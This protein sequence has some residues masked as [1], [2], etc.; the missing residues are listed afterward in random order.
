VGRAAPPLRAPEHTTLD[1]T[2]RRGAPGRGGYVGLRTGPG[3]PHVLRTDLA[4]PSARRAETRTALLAFAHL[5]DTH[6]VDAQSPARAEFLSRYGGSLRGGHRP[7][8]MLATQVVDAMAQAVRRSDRGPVTGRPLDLA[9]S[10]GDNVDNRQYNEVRWFLD[11]FDGGRT[12]TPDSGDRRRWEGVSDQDLLSYDVHYWHP[13]GQPAGREVDRLRAVHGYPTLPG[14]LDAC[15][16]PFTSTGLGV[17][18]YSVYGNHD[19][20]IQ[21][22]LQRNPS[23]GEYAVG[24][25]KHVGVG[26]APSDLPDVTPG[27]LLGG[28][29]RLVTPDPDRR[30]LTK[31]EWVA[32]HLAKPGTPHGHG[33]TRRNVD[34]DTAYYAADLTPQVRLLTLD[35]TT[36]GGY[37][38][39][40]LDVVQRDWLEAQLKRSSSRYLAPDGSWVAQ[41]GVADRLV[42]IASHH[43]VA[44]M[45]NVLLAPGETAPRVQ[46]DEV[47]ALLLRFPNVVA[48]INGHT[49]TNAV[50]PHKGSAGGFWEVTSASHIDW[51]QQSRLVELVDNR[52]GTL[53]LFGTVIDTAAASTGGLHSPL[54]LA[55]LSRELSANDPNTRADADPDARRGRAEGRNVELVVRAPFALTRR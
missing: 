21:G 50:T 25:V 54:A 9:L 45:D 28:P 11:L 46:G 26:P 53:S 35:S 17:P 37:D 48:W 10:T 18:W 51:P 19:G 44:T 38:T 4:T 43:T 47:L 31:R 32:E 29:A 16:R 33:F 55:G 2:L 36:P 30:F 7:H 12:V 13:D 27:V 52:D 49:H 41:P 34:D 24:P 40:S 15:R 14:L 22:T 42:L 20:A 1:S 23:L 5:T 8:E 39:G 3:E 6:V